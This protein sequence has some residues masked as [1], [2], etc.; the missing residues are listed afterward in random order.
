[1]SH[2]RQERFIVS[3]KSNLSVPL[4]SPRPETPPAGNT[5]FLSLSF[6]VPILPHQSC[7]CNETGTI[8]RAV[9]DA[10]WLWLQTCFPYCHYWGYCSGLITSLLS[11]PFQREL[12]RPPSP[13]T[14][15]CC[16]HFYPCLPPSH[17]S[18]TLLALLW[19]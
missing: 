5:L 16:S 4:A 3:N 6:H 13:P 18:K 10:K 7:F 17:N 12:N 15:V 8:L 1:M 9:P 14:Q 2:V 11:R 19:I